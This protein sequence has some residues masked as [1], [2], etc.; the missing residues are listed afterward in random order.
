MNYQR[1]WGKT[2]HDARAIHPLCCHGLDSAAVFQVML[3]MEKPLA[4]RL[5]SL[6]GRSINRLRP[7]LLFLVALHD[8]GKFGL[9]F[10]YQA[11]WAAEGLGLPRFR[12]QPG[13]K[14]VDAGWW[15]W[16]NHLR[17]H[18]SGSS[19]G[20]AGSLAGSWAAPLVQAVLGHHGGPAQ[21]QTSHARAF[22][23]SAVADALA[24]A[25][26]LAELFLSDTGPLD[27]NEDAA[28]RLSWLFAGLTVISDW[29]ASNQEYFPA[30]HDPNAAIRLDMKEYYEEQALPA[31]REAVAES[32][33]LRPAPA[34]DGGFN[35][36][37]P[38]MPAE[39]APRRLQA[40]ALG[41]AVEGSGPEL[42][43]FED[44]TGNGKTEAALACAHRLMRAGLASGIYFA[45]PTMATANAMYS[46][47]AKTYYSLFAE[48]PSMALAH[49]ARHLVQG[50]L[51][52]IPLENMSATS[53]SERESSEAFCSRWLADNRKKALLAPCGV[54]TLDQA[55]LGVL[56]ARH[57]CLRLAGLARGVLIADEVHGY[58][59]YTL[60]LL[61][62]LLTFQAALGGSAILLSATLPHKVRARLV[63]A[64]RKGRGLL[65]APLPKAEFPLA[66]R[67]TD[68]ALRH[69]HKEV[70]SDRKLDIA[71]ELVH[72]AAEIVR[73]L[74]G[75]AQAGACGCWVRNTVDDAIDA[76]R[77]LR[78][79]FRRRGL[80]P[81]NVILHHARFTLHDRLGTEKAIL[82]TFG[83]QP[84]S[85]RAGK[86]VV[87]TQVLE[88]SIDADWDIM[89]SDLAPM[90]ALIQR[91]GRCQRHNLPRPSGFEQPL[92]LVLGPEP[93]SDAP[94]DWY[95]RFFPIGRYVYR[96]P[97]LL[98]RTARILAGKGA[99]R[100]PEEARNLVEG[101]YNDGQDDPQ[102]L[103][104]LDEEEWGAGQG[105]KSLADYNLL[106][107]DGGYCPD[108]SNH[109]WD[110]DE[111]AP[112]RLGE[113]TVQVRLLK[114]DA[115]G[116]RLY[117]G[118]RPDNP[119][120]CALSEV[121]VRAARARE[122]VVPAGIKAQVHAL[123]K[124]MRDEGE[125]ALILPLEPDGQEW[126][127][128]VKDGKGE[129]VVVRY[130]ACG[131]VFG[132]TEQH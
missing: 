28:R 73:R 39:A 1:Y 71:V 43:I 64:W 30:K 37:F 104:A 124:A 41:E 77:E 53:T 55:L 91:A 109:G 89:A 9:G 3:E 128:R 115:D 19:N 127:G 84:T 2:S 102:A 21:H 86:V 56:S 57:Q 74:A 88:Q 26:A 50:F 119:R 106:E 130:G 118:G 82:D 23:A 76:W 45:L 46:R 93:V 114:A 83:K 51:E 81:E 122:A 85:P 63:E 29:I 78:E 100:L 75:A 96:M 108:S 4:D 116:V 72:D 126:V 70:L 117:S 24:Y 113:M 20:A 52:S 22:G 65:P 92:L 48:K 111:R 101:A 17:N 12:L 5:A 80:D 99:I 131:F 18:F 58:D 66:T 38:D 27:M 60:R 67:V 36:L 87:G 13:L 125:D 105:K 107:V 47:L 32:G 103:F 11:R 54:G 42:H 31:A 79:E 110:K 129:E 40:Y 62:G 15:L 59:A 16:S 98:W 34:F 7:I 10:Q 33:L 121:R 120:D 8:V 123:K 49:G 68:S 69:T 44:L 132:E 95:A 35:A 94:A 61:E 14:H 97:C 25:D 112:T 6:S 90:D